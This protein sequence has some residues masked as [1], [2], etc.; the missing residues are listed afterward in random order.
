MI[1]LRMDSRHDRT[2]APAR[3]RVTVKRKASALVRWGLLAV[4]WATTMDVG[5][6]PMTSLMN[7][8][9]SHFYDGNMNPKV[10]MKT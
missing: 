5:F 1:K 10:Y 9:P 7:C 6:K 3:S 4:T 2:P 8:F